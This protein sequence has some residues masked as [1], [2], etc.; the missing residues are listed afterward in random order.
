MPFEF[1]EGEGEADGAAAVDE[2]TAGD[3]RASV[4][5]LLEAMRQLLSN[6]HLPDPPGEEGEADVDQS[7]DDDAEDW[8]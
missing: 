2:S 8:N 7:E 6:I 5:T 1:S 3:L 4:N